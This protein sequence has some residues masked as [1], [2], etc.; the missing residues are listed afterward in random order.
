MDPFVSSAGESFLLYVIFFV[1]S[2]KSHFEGH[3]GW[4]GLILFNTQ[5]QGFMHVHAH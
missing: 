4:I 2:D 5:L 3:I 1:L